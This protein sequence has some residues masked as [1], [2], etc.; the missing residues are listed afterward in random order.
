MN[1]TRPLV[2]V[3][4]L[5]LAA[6]SLSAELVETTIMARPSMSGGLVLFCAMATAPE[7][8]HGHAFVVVGR[9]GGL[10]DLRVER[11]LGMTALDGAAG[12]AFGEVDAEAVAGVCG[13]PEAETLLVRTDAETWTKAL[14]A[15]EGRLDP[16][17]E[18]YSTGARA[19]FLGW[20]MVDTLGI[21]RGYARRR[22]RLPPSS[23]I[24]FYQDLLLVN[25]D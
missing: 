1:D 20:D 19:L 25:R 8:E 7:A 3:V 15:L 16:E 5:G 17:D 12:E 6:A 13:A 9:G 4:V 10:E 23:A 14:A 22:S 11:A 24:S 21:D 2:L 18:R